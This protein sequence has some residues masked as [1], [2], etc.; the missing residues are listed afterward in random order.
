RTDDGR[1]RA[2]AR[3]VKFGRSAHSRLPA[4]SSTTRPSASDE[5]VRWQRTDSARTTIGDWRGAYRCK[6]TQTSPSPTWDDHHASMGETNPI[7]E[8]LPN[9][10]VVDVG[11][12]SLV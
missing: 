9:K 8:R 10:V 2:K 7:E 12:S 4:L 5:A 11:R 6:P 3:G 1:K